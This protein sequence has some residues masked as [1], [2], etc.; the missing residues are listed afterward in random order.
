MRHTSNSIRAAHGA[1]MLLG[2]FSLARACPAAMTFSRSL[3]PR[4]CADIGPELLMNP[5]FRDITQVNTNTAPWRRWEERANSMSFAEDARHDALLLMRSSPHAE[6]WHVQLW[7]DVQLKGLGAYQLCVRASSTL[8]GTSIR[9]G[10]ESDHPLY[11][12]AGGAPRGWLKLLKP[13]TYGSACLPFTL[14][15]GTNAYKGRAVLDLGWALG[16]VS[17]C[18]VS[19][20]QCSPGLACTLSGEDPWTSGRLI[21]CC[22]GLQQCLADWMGDGVQSYRCLASCAEAMRAP[23]ELIWSDEF[24]VAEEDMRPDS[25]K[26]T[27][28]LGAGGWGN[29]ELQYYTDRVENAKVADGVLTITAQCEKYF[30]ARYTSARLATKHK[31]DWGPGIRVDVRAKLPLGVGSWPAIWMLPTDW[32][33]GAWP[34]SG[35]I[36]IMEHAGCGPGL[37]HG[38]VHTNAYNWVLDTQK[39]ANRST[40]PADGW[41]LHSISWETSRITW[42]IDGLEYFRFN[43]LKETSWEEWPFDKRFHLLLNVAVGGTWG[44]CLI[45]APSCTDPAQFGSPQ[46]MSVDYVRIFRLGQDTSAHGPRHAPTSRASRA[47]RGRMAA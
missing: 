6:V 14:P 39:T 22:S 17:L 12:P 2:V 28:D 15:A 30:G 24:E 41:H 25:T 34:A 10:I 38:S 21:K 31:G 46:I 1:L 40:W 44:T 36:D 26:W 37:L 29:E 20:V 16:N 23:S 11:A 8:P 43:K 27:Y 5:T 35:E 33:Y 47:K 13:N 4:G 9:F 7:Q 42:F 32:A 19:L 3:F 45:S 18:E